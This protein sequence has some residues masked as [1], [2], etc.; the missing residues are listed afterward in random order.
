MASGRR[1]PDVPRG[2]LA[3]AHAHLPA[4]TLIAVAGELDFAT[5]GEL[6]SYIERARRDRG[7]GEHLVFDLSEVPFIDSAGLRVL[8]L[9]ASE[10]RRYGGEVRLAALRHAPSRLLA[11]TGVHAHVWVHDTVQDAIAAAL[12]AH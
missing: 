3:L 8:L 9:C 1:R 6:E 4:V 12:G 5:A 7:R 10:T 2:P 11:V